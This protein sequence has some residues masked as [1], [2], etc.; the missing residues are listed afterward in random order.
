M[1]C[2]LKKALESFFPF[3]CSFLTT[4][5]DM[6]YPSLKKIQKTFIKVVKMSRFAVVRKS[7]LLSKRCTHKKRI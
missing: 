5:Y 6:Y 3:Y 4:F 1:K 7:I 2:C